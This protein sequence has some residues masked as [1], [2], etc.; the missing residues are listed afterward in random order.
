MN[1]KH[2]QIER[3]TNQAGRV[4]QIHAN[5]FKEAIRK[6]RN[7]GKICSVCICV[8]MCVCVHI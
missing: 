6:R 8:C 2:G 3:V 5:N 1:D 4:K 7:I